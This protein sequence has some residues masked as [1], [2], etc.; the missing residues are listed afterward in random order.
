MFPELPSHA[1]HYPVTIW[2]ISAL[3]ALGQACRVL[4]RVQISGFAG[5]CDTVVQLCA[6]WHGTKV[7]L[8][9]FK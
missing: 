5:L 1:V 7:R 4:K 2:I 3:V 9:R 6:I 8:A